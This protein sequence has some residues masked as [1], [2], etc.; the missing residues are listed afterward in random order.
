[1]KIPPPFSV[2]STSPIPEIR[3]FKVTGELDLATL[4]ALQEQFKTL[5]HDLSAENVLVDLGDCDFIDS[6]AIEYITELSQQAEASAAGSFTLCALSAPVRGTF[7]VSGLTSR[8]HIAADRADALAHL[9][10]A[11]SQPPA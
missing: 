5:E 1:M 3:C 11:G 10:A 7:D 6:T 9:Q 4:P 2:T 8:L